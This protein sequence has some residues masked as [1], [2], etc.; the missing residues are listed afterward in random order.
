MEATNKRLTSE[1]LDKL[2]KKHIT[3]N[4]QINSSPNQFLSKMI[5]QAKIELNAEMTVEE[6][7]QIL[8]DIKVEIN[9]E[10]YTYNLAFEPNDDELKIKE[11]G[12]ATGREVYYHWETVKDIVH[13]IKQEK[14]FHSPVGNEVHKAKE[15]KPKQEQTT[16]Q[17]GQTTMNNNVIIG[18]IDYKAI[19]E[20]KYININSADECKRVAD[21]LVENGVPFSGRIQPNLQKGTITVSPENY[22]AV[23]DI[24]AK[25]KSTSPAEKKNTTIGNKPYKYIYDKKYINSNE[26]EIRKLADILTR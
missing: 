21:T 25:V 9:Y 20:K 16:V 14:V 7:K 15:L 11:S 26:E 10:G 22:K 18:T 23:I 8:T 2:A 1:D 6:I 4:R 17:K 12:S 13:N 19:K 5:K 3:L 24:L